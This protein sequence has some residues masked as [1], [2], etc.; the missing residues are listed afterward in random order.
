MKNSLLTLHRYLGLLLAGFLFIAGVTGSFLA[1][2]YEF[3][4]LL[5]PGLFRVEQAGQAALSPTE[6]AQAVNAWD[7]RI[8]IF[9]LPIPA[10]PSRATVAYVE[11]VDNPQTG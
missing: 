3:D 9:Y 11:P 4:A 1:F 6:L 7:E 2:Y 8:R 10:R 5:N